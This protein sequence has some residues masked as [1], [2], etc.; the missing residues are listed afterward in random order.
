MPPVTAAGGLRHSLEQRKDS[1]DDHAQAATDKDQT[2][3]RSSHRGRSL[4]L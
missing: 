3:F 2:Y 1:Q 4:K